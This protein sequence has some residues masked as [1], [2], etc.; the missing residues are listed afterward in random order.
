MARLNSRGMAT[1]LELLVGVGLTTMIATS[2]YMATSTG[3]SS[4]SVAS[5]AMTAQDQLRRALAEIA[6]GLRNSGNEDALARVRVNED[7]ACPMLIYQAP[8]HASGYSGI[9]QPWGIIIPPDTVLNG[10]AEWVHL[11]NAA[12]GSGDPCQGTFLVRQSMTTWA[13]H[14]AN[15]TGVHAI[16]LLAN[17]VTLFSVQAFD[18]PGNS[19]NWG[20]PSWNE[21]AK[22][23][24]VQLQITQPSSAG[25][26]VTKS[27]MVRVQLRNRHRE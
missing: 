18:E 21:D 20:S 24:Q 23:V 9:T 13:D 4:F 27:Q 8:I 15:P 12:D 17:N 26:S 1:F 5:S 6:N 25:P 3:S 2:L 11:S 10:G 16:R 22:Q 7:P 19:V 14:N